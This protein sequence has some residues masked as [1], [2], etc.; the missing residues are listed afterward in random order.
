MPDYASNQLAASA[1]A[2]S[3]GG[4]VAERDDIPENPVTTARNR[5]L[6]ST[7]R[8]VTLRDNLEHIAIFQLGVPGPTPGVGAVNQPPREGESGR[9]HDDLDAL[10]QVIDSLMFQVGRL[11]PLGVDRQVMALK[12]SGTTSTFIR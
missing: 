8:I 3:F 9:L 1:N 6:E 7:A 10:H 4:A 12:S 2:R 5:I 11:E